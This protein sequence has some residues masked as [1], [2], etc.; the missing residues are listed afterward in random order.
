MSQSDQSSS[1]MPIYFEPGKTPY[2]QCPNYP[3]PCSHGEEK[4]PADAQAKQAGIASLK[5]LS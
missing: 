1:P 3:A 4:C 5:R 2:V